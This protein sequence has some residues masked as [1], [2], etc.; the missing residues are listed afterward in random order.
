VKLSVVISLVGSAAKPLDSFE[1]VL[2][3]PAT[4]IMNFGKEQLSPSVALVR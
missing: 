2:Q 1:V 3:R 4:V